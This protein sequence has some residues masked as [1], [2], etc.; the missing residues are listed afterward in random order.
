MTPAPRMTYKSAIVESIE[1]VVYFSEYIA[2]CLVSYN[3]RGAEM[4]LIS[5]QEEQGCK[6]A[7]SDVASKVDTCGI[8]PFRGLDGKLDDKNRFERN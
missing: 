7:G 3:R 2:N 4:V 6:A 8:G 1:C 5:E